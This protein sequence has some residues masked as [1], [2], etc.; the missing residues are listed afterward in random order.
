MLHQIRQGLVN[1]RSLDNVIVIQNERDV[2]SLPTNEVVGE[3]AQHRQKVRRLWRGEQS[4]RGSA[5]V[6]VKRLQGSNE[7]GKESGGLIVLLLKREP[8]HRRS[9]LGHPL[10]QQGRF[11]KTGRC[12][13]ECERACHSLLKPLDEVGAGHKLGTGAW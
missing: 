3:H 7:I 12:R 4:E 10:G 1:G 6:W 9:A 5:K 11:P 8:G 13:D 2:L